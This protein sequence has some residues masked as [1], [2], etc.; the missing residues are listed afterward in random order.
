MT[1]TKR[2]LLSGPKFSNKHGSVIPSA[3]PYLVALRAHEAV[4]KVVLS[5]IR[6]TRGT[7]NGW[8]AIR[9]PAGLK[10]TVRGVSAVQDFYVY[11]SDPDRVE[12]ALATARQ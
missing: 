4:T 1:P 7:S 11:T 8:K 3:H 2:G 10:L 12:A 5:E 9:V 6:H